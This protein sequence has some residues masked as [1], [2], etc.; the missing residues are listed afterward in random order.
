MEEIYT[1]NKYYKE[2]FGCKVYKLSLDAGMTCPNRDGTLDTRGCIFCSSGGSGD[3]ASSRNLSI[4]DQISEAKLRIGN[5]FTGNK[6]IAYFQAYTN[7]YA[8]IEYL[9]RI[10]YEALSCPDIVGLSIATRPDCIN[11]EVISLLSEI[12]H[13]APVFVE[14][15][16]QTIHENTAKLIRRGYSLDVFDNAVRHL[17]DMNINTVIHLILGL[18]FETHEDMLNSVRY[19]NNLPINGIKLQLLHILKDTD[20]AELYNDGVFDTL[21][22]EDYTVILSECIESLRPDIVV[23]RITGDGKKS[24]LISPLWSANKKLVLNY[25][26][27]YFKENNIIQGRRYINGS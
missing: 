8:P 22:L 3:F 27:K 15:G 25:I 26:N 14:L 7:T 20:L 19:L 6:Y 11:D 16:L 10:Y 4:T 2:R 21:S 5:K 18:P 12:N 17:S 24:Q 9:R 13:T 1:L 23:H